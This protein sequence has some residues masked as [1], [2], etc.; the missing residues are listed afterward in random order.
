LFEDNRLCDECLDPQSAG[1]ALQLRSNELELGCDMRRDTVLIVDNSTFRRNSAARGGAVSIDTNCANVAVHATFRTSTFDSNTAL[2]A[3]SGSGGAIRIAFSSMDRTPSLDSFV[4]EDSLFQNNSAATNGGAL[5][6][7]Q[8]EITEFGVTVSVVIERTRI[9]DNRARQDSQLSLLLVG[10]IS[11]ANSTI[12][13]TVIPGADSAM[14]QMLSVENLG[15]ALN[16]ENSLLSCASGHYM[17]LNNDTVWVFDI[18]PSS[19]FVMQCLMCPSS[20]H[21]LVGEPAIYN[22]SSIRQPSVF[23]CHPCPLGA[24]HNCTGDAVGASPG[25]WSSP[26]REANQ[27]TL[28]EFHVCPAHYCCGD[29]DGCE[30]V[31]ACDNNRTGSLCGACMPEF[32]HA[33]SLHDACV[34]KEACSDEVVWVG[35]TVV[36][37]V[38][39][40]FVLY[41]FLRKSATSDGL[42]KVLV[43]FSNI[44]QVVVSNSIALGPVDETSH[45]GFGDFIRAVF[46]LLS[47]MVEVQSSTIAYCP[48][49]SM[50]SLEKLMMPLGVPIVLIGFWALMSVI[51]LVVWDARVTKRYSDRHC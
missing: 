44:A 3:R 10:D 42:L 21:N 4:V 50:T 47:G 17:V 32:V 28:V 46:S 38:C 1:G 36:V 45:S 9:L 8:S 41:L 19:R 27:S 26:P 39:A 14:Q 16:V 15:D 35:N 7:T 11:I 6:L 2:S 31:D 13:A 49:A 43:S 25:F 29:V 40:A 33:F 30:R 12:G 5:A 20:T 23:Q 37:V 34:P 51:A 22:A 48:K 24:R 18:D